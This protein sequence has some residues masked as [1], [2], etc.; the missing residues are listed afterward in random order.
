RDMP[1][2]M[3]TGA[4][5]RGGASEE[6]SAWVPMGQSASAR[7]NTTVA[8]TR[9]A[10]RWIAG[11]SANCLTCFVIGLLNPY[12]RRWERT[13]AMAVRSLHSSS[14]S[15]FHLLPFCFSLLFTVF[16]RFSPFF[17]AF[18]RFSRRWGCP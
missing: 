14:V 17:T 16:H 15:W 1:T 10:G 12:Q 2:E 13:V 4:D 18:H 11:T 3:E 5:A 6:A 9:R 7:S 8:P